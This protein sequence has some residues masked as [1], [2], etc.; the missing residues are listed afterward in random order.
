MMMEN[1]ELRLSGLAVFL[2]LA[3]RPLSFSDGFAQIV[4]E[5]CLGHHSTLRL[6]ENE[7]DG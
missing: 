7:P 3:N 2:K 4:E 1:Q 5:M 6:K